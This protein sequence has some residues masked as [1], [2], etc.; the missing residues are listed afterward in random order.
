MPLIPF[1]ASVAAD[2][3]YALR[4]L[5]NTPGITAIAILTLALGLG[6][7]TAM[8]TLTWNIVLK[9]LPVPRPHE[10]VEYSLTNGEASPGMSIPLYKLLNE[11]QQTLTGLLA[12]KDDANVIVRVGA[13]RSLQTVE[14]LTPNALSLLELA[15]AIGQPLQGNATTVLSEAYARQQFGSPAQALGQTLAVADRTVTVSG[16]LPASF[17]GL[18]ANLPPAIYLPISFAKLL[19]HDDAL[20]QAGNIHFSVLGRLKPG[21]NLAQALAEAHA[22]EPN[23][24][25]D[26]DPGGIYLGQ[27]FKAFRLTVMPGNSG[28]SWLRTTYQTPLLALEL[29]VA[30]LL[31]LC[32]ANAALV[33]LAR[34]SGRHHEYAVALALGAPRSAITRQVL[35][36][37]LVLTLPALA[38]ALLFGWA[39]AHTLVSMLGGNWDPALNPHDIP[40]R[41]DS[42]IFAVSAALTLLLALGTGL[43]PAWQAAGRQPAFDL[44]LAGRTVASRRAGVWS[45][46]LQVA[47]S[48]AMVSAAWLLGGALLRF[49]N[50]HSGFELDR[51]ATAT[52]DLSPLQPKGSEGNQLF[53]RLRDALAAQPGVQAIGFV[54]PLPLSGHSA[55]SRAF[56]IDREHRIHSA[57][58]LY[59]QSAT[60][61]YFRAAGTTVVAADPSFADLKPESA[62]TC[63]LSQSLANIFFPG[64]DPLGQHTYYS[65]IGV[66]DGTN[67]D[68]KNACR[69]VAVVEDARY[70]SLRQPAVPMIYQFFDPAVHSEYTDNSE[71]EVMVR[72]ASTSLAMAAL[73]I[74]LA[75]TIPREAI[76]RTQSFRERAD[77]D[78]GRERVLLA[79]SGSFAMLALLLTGLGLHGLLMRSVALRQ[80]EIGIRLALGAPRGFILA[81]LAQPV[82]QGVCVG[83]V[84]GFVLAAL[85]TQALNR[86]F[87]LPGA[88]SGIQNLAGCAV[89]ALSLVC[90]SA[91]SF[92]A[93]ARRA[94][95][96]D[97]IEALRTE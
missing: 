89:A 47:L 7:S 19:D 21:V 13:R 33:M 72:A 40:T 84:A 82:L 49:A 15:P 50:G 53:A 60:P 27:F 74:A 31:V 51:A 77:A 48:L 90:I 16:V 17:T 52:I 76:V 38:L 85:L 43:L 93:P 91:A 71:T 46:A 5:R 78:L 61:D 79:L 88:G 44:K 6:A 45:I 36:E 24:R 58:S 2:L 4:R 34:V 80:R 30:L 26:A 87:E 92:I 75:A 12:F 18:T 65:T 14:M 54:N 57:P 83:L 39:G 73:K 94:A 42:V 1:T 29:L 35:I 41:P 96:I 95:S 37:S 68:P 70:V 62:P 8:F 81:P 66:P 67:L 9:S 86:L 25:H 32:A 10:L 20:I 69:I 23:L 55:I 22:L 56:S 59:F 97:P 11:R 64:E 28:N 63:A 3:C